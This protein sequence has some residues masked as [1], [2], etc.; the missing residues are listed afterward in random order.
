MKKIVIGVPSTTTLISAAFSKSLVHTVQFGLEND[1]A[2]FVEFN[3]TTPWAEVNKTT[4]ANKVLASETADGVVF[5]SPT[6]SWSPKSLISLINS[7]KDIVS[8]IF[9]EPT[10]VELLYNV[11]LDENM[12]IQGSELLAEYVNMD[13]CYV[14]KEALSK[15]SK[16]CEV[17]PDNEFFWFFK[18]SLENGMFQPDY[19]NFCKAALYAGVP[20]NVE[21]T[22]DFSNIG[23]INFEGNFEKHMQTTW[24]NSQ[25]ELQDI[26]RGLN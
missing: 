12:D 2:F 16:H 17:A 25:A 7:G 13:A 5:L 20:I 21:K 10:T 9:P 11:K 22:A 8:G 4:I 19:V 24:V 3:S 14:S 26:E 18:S 6:L 15:I 1:I 23:E